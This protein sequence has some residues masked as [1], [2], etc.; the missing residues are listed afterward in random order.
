AFFWSYPDATTTFFQAG[1]AG[2]DVRF[3]SSQNFSTA[4]NPTATAT[5]VFDAT[6]SGAIA[7]VTNTNNFFTGGVT[8]KGG[9]L[10]LELATAFPTAVAFT[11]PGGTLALSVA[12]GSLANSVTLA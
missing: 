9:I 6:N 4:N 5:I 2:S 3:T 7:S 12:S 10:R 8:V 11:V 1:A